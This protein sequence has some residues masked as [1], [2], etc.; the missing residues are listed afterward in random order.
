MYKEKVFHIKREK[1]D[2]Q[3]IIKI[4]GVQPGI[5]NAQ[6]I[7]LYPNANVEERHMSTHIMH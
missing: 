7:L 3:V 5:T 1:F 6:F 2:T 4:R